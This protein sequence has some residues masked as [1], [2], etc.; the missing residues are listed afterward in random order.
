MARGVAPFESYDSLTAAEICG[1]LGSLDRPTLRAI[2][3]WE[4]A[5][6]ARVTV[7]RRVD[8]RLESIGPAVQQRTTKARSAKSRRQDPT[9]LAA[10]API[11]EPVFAPVAQDDVPPA[12][13]AASTSAATQLVHP[14]LA[15]PTSLP[16][17]PSP[18]YVP[19]A[20]G[21]AGGI[22]AKVRSWPRW[23]KVAGVA[24]VVILAVAPFTSSKDGKGTI[25][26]SNALGA[27]TTEPRGTSAS[28]PASTTTTA[29]STT[30]TTT[31]TTTSTTTPPTTT[32]PA[33]VPPTTAY[34][35]PTTAYAPPTTAYIPPTTP[36]APPNPS[37]AVTPGAFCAPLG[38]TGY[39]SNGV[40]M[41][42][43]ASS[44]TGAPYTQP[45]WHKTVC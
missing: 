7:L 32:V 23:A 15:A 12:Q 3:R 27:A 26:T 1:L 38:A 30:T 24:L 44:C 4:A 16:L 40:P 8:A 43:S 29:S 10:S 33:T 34:V 2:R 42:C 37:G 25:Q 20:R 36:D 6:K 45:R 14:R 5:N 41:T 31:S 21:R 13:E 22:A 28:I 11:G 39:S 17:P 35:P 9:P 19:P 18:A